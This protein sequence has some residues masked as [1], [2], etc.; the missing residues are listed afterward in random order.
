L[1]VLFEDS[2]YEPSSKVTSKNTKYIS[3]FH[4]YYIKNFFTPHGK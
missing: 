2:N 3:E 1:E 4:I